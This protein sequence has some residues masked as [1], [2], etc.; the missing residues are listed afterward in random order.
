VEPATGRL[1]AKLENTPA[2]TQIEQRICFTPDGARMIVPHF[3]DGVFCVWDLEAIRANLRTMK[4]DWDAPPLAKSRRGRHAPARIQVHMGAL[5]K[6]PHVIARKA[7]I[8][9]GQAIALDPDSAENW[10]QRGRA[11]AQLGR[12]LE[13]LADFAE[14][15]RRNPELIEA[16][17]ERV[18]VHWD[19]KRFRDAVKDSDEGLRRKSDDAALHFCKG[20]SHLCLLEYREAVSAYERSLELDP[21]QGRICHDLA[22][23]FTFG[24][25]ELRDPQ[26]ALPLAERAARLSK[27]HPTDLLTLGIVHYHLDRLEEARRYLEKVAGVASTSAAGNWAAPENHFYL[28]MTYHK[29]GMKDKAQARR[30]QG[31]SAL[32]AAGPL[33]RIYQSDIDRIRQEVELLL[34]DKPR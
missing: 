22:R 20:L 12:R 4:L 3:K 13:A 8:D 18:A 30:R 5:A 1:L 10:R 23:I 15:L 28:A 21:D 6:H 33:F 11:N 34:N 17:R 31:L 24:P 7:V 14:A 19:L 29:L 16:Y 2:P 26:K 32:Q 9:A 25:R 27:Q